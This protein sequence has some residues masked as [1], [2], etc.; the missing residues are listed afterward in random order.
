VPEVIAA[1]HMG[2]RV[3]ALSVI[4]DECFPDALAPVT[5]EDVLAAAD[6]A[7]PQLTAIMAGVVERI[8]AN[9]SVTS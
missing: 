3:L 1:R 8:G 9:T 4:T 5:L 6:A 7:E 2:L